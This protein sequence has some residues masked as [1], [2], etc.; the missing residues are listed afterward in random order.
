M[1]K[2]DLVD[3]VVTE[4]RFP[5]KGSVQVL[6]EDGTTEHVTVKNVIP[7]QQV[8][9]RVTRTGHGRIEGRLQEILQPSSF[10]LSGDSVCPHFNICGGCLMQSVP[11]DKQLEIKSAE[12]RQLF[13]PVMGEELFDS[14]NEGIIGSPK[15]SEYRNKMELSF[16]NEEKDGPLRLGMHRRGSFYDIEE[17]YDCRIMDSVFRKILT[18][19]ADY[20]RE[21]ELS[22]FHKMAHTGYLRHLLLRKGEKSN[23]Y[24]IDLITSTD[25]DPE[26]EKYMLREWCDRLLS[27]I[28]GGEIQGILHTRNDR[29]ADAVIDEGTDILYGTDYFYDEILGLDFK[30]TPFSFFQTN[31]L[32]A[33]KLYET[34]REFITGRNYSNDNE[35]CEEKNVEKD[36][37]K[38]PDINMEKSIEEGRFLGEVFDLYSGTGTIAQVLSPAATHVTGVEIVE[39]AVEAARENAELNRLTNCDFIAGDVFKVLESLDTI[40]DTIVLDPPRDGV[41]QKALGKILGYGVKNI[42]Y[43]ACKPTSL[44]RDIP[45]FMEA[46]YK[47][48]RFKLVDMFP[49]TSGVEA[50]IKFSK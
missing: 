20:Y 4:L 46:G 27:E 28:N 2:G 40:P 47:A 21:K 35:V 36:I 5:N 42:I 3:G 43:I 44:A 11:Y 7:E 23:Q 26:A 45:A 15:S 19:T 39:E 22:F 24:L 34:A 29:S 1:K 37:D 10:E 50:M 8:R 41:S 25:I 18:I 16:G 31:T 6:T 32:G 12:M 38:K 17:V 48:D 33:E 30:V 14:I 13:V 9:L 49:S